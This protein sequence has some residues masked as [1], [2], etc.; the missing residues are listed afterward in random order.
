MASLNSAI[1]LIREGRKDEAR[2]ILEPLLKTE[3]ANI[4]AWFWYVEACP[5]PEMRIQVLEVCLKINPG[6]S[7]VMQ[8]LQTLRNQRPAQSSYTPPPP[9]P[10][11][12][13]PSQPSSL[14]SGW[15][16]ED[17]S[18]PTSPSSNEPVFVDSAP[19]YSQ[20]DSYTPT[21][22]QKTGKQKNAWEVDT[23]SYVDN[24]LLSK[25]KPAAK[26][27][28]FY[29]VWMTVL[30]SFDIESYENVLNDPEA[31]AGR[32]FEWIA[33]TGIISGLLAPFSLLSNPQF[34]EIRNTAEFNNLF[35]NMGMT[36]LMVVMSL[37]LALLTPLFSVIG[38]AISAG[39]QN[40]FA[41]MFGGKGY[42]GRTV[43]ALAAYLAP[44]SI[45]VA[46]LGIIP[47][48]GQCATSLLGLYNIILNVR[49][50]RAAHSISVWQALG[51]MFAP[52]IILIILGCLLVL[53]IGL[54]GLSN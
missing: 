8:A 19:T 41:L 52:T 6:N 37:A 2:Q 22:G 4:Q 31:G 50:L 42:Y 45:L 36:A 1:Q 20:F 7:Q 46:A 25:P 38:L 24:S 17:E 16:E 33:Y 51:V 34:A 23:G 21:Q 43:Y 10:E 49:A 9:K 12:P 18:K 5:T 30:A 13:E 15:Y 3:P 39:I 47:L 53:V 44:M 32:G 54:P 35:G 40:F 26:S 14:Y 29:D 27:Y 48:V 28:A 11:I